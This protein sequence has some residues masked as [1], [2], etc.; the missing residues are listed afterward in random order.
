MTIQ[1]H[2]NMPKTYD[3]SQTEHP[4][5]RF[6]ATVIQT[7]LRLIFYSIYL[8]VAYVFTKFLFAVKRKLRYVHVF[9]FSF[10]FSSFST[11]LF[12]CSCSGR[13]GKAT[14]RARWICISPLNTTT[15]PGHFQNTTAEP[16]DP[17]L[18]GEIY[19]PFW[20]RLCY[21]SDLRLHN[22]DQTRLRRL[23]MFSEV[24]APFV[25]SGLTSAEIF[26]SFVQQ[27]LS[28]E[29]THTVLL[30]SYKSNAVLY[31]FLFAREH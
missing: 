10:S 2:I 14:Q 30:T 23:V 3:E 4:T 31:K 18:H 25:L 20:V 15:E 9:S 27:S 19:N 8:F 13:S 1:K 11:E 22:N 28:A 21:Y 12:F 26:L 16:T 6:H 24:S 17:R 7:Q 29:T 5:L